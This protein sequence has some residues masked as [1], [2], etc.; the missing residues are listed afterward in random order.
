MFTRRGPGGGLG[1]PCKAASNIAGKTDAL[2]S[3]GPSLFAWLSNTTRLDANSRTMTLTSR[4]Y[5]GDS[6]PPKG[7]I[8]YP[9]PGP[10]PPPQAQPSPG[11]AQG[12]STR[13][14][15]AVTCTL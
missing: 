12:D 4:W 3:Q 14:S 1:K 13:C 8:A 6:M 10:K 2:S 9:N 11:L 5:Q 15:L 7:I